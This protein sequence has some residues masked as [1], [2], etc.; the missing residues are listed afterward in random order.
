[1]RHAKKLISVIAFA[2]VIATA[3]ARADNL[4]FDFNFD[5][6]TWTAVTAP[7]SSAGS[8]HVGSPAGS[9]ATDAEI[10]SVL[11]SLTALQF[12]GSGAGICAGTSCEGFTV[13]LS[14]P[15]LGNV[16]SDD[17]TSPQTKSIWSISGGNSTFWNSVGGNPS[18]G[19]LEGG[20]FSVFFPTQIV[21]SAPASFLGDEGA[22]FGKNLTVSMWAVGGRVDFTSGEITLAGTGA[23]PTVPEPQSLT[24]IVC[25]AGMLGITGR[26]LV[27]RKH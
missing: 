14:N 20:T 24:L 26:L 21:L 7:L 5:Q 10:A 12:S 4:F 6:T 22:A 23:T 8:W 25:G 1:M 16:V 13:F 19:Y 15:N 2:F 17:L 18:G 9:L 11:Q 3:A 27:L